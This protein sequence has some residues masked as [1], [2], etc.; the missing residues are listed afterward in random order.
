V[1]NV[2]TRSGTRQLHGEA[3]DYIRNDMFDAKP[4]FQDSIP[5]LKQNQFGDNLG[6]PLI[7]H[8]KAFFFVDYQGT[9]LHQ[10]DN[11]NPTVI[12]T[13]TTLERT[14]DFW[15]SKPVPQVSCNGLKGIICPSAIDPVAANLLKFVPV[16]FR[17]QTHRAAV[18]ERR[19]HREPGDGTPRLRWFSA[20]LLSS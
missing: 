1:V 5:P 4:Y 19:Q 9:I 10:P 6:G 20:L 3:Y 2:I 16:R 11:V 7:R 17:G 18:F 8:G 15:Q 13:A 14:G 12:V